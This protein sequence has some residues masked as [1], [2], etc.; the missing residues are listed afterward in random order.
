MKFNVAVNII[1]YPHIWDTINK[2]T[3]K[4]IELVVPELSG[5]IFSVQKV[6]LLWSKAVDTRYYHLYT[7]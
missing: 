3:R 2:K 1:V 6:F 7:K 5:I 4:Y